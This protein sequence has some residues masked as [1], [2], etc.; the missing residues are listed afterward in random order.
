MLKIILIGLDFVVS[1][2]IVVEKFEERKFFLRKQD[3]KISYN[4]YKMIGIFLFVE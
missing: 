1:M 2:Y 4:I 3:Y